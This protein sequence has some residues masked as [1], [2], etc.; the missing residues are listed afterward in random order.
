MVGVR[1]HIK[2]SKVTR[3]ELISEIKPPQNRVEEELYT[4]LKG[5]R[6]LFSFAVSYDV[7][8]F[9]KQVYDA[10][11]QIPYGETRSYGWVAKKIGKPK[12]QRA[13]GQAL[14]KNPLPLFVPCH[15]VIGKHQDLVGFGSGLDKKRALLALEKRH[16]ERLN[17]ED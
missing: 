13:V 2:N 6:K 1:A 17:D 16:K 4:F 9:Q 11:R 3:I 7:T 8:A 12:A 15:R 10:T 14:N 5:E